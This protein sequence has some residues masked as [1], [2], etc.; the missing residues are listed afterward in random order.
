[1]VAAR[2]AG[3]SGVRVV[4]SNFPDNT[5]V[6]SFELLDQ[7]NHPLATMVISVETNSPAPLAAQLNRAVKAKRCL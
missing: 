6:A 7:D 1:M 4:R 3:A 5:V 2:Q